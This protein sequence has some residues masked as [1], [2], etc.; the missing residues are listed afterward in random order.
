MFLGLIDC[1]GSAW[2]SGPS[3]GV[4][5]FQ[6]EPARAACSSATPLEWFPRSPGLFHTKRGEIARED[7]AHYRT[8]RSFEEHHASPHPIVYDLYGKIR[9]LEGGLGCIRLLPKQTECGTLWF[10]S[11]SSTQSAHEGVPIAMSDSD[12]NKC[13]GY[14]TQH[15]VMPCSITGRLRFLPKP[16]LSLYGD[17]VDVPGLYLLVEDLEPARSYAKLPE[18]RPIVSVA[19]TFGAAGYRASAAAHRSPRRQFASRPARSGPS[20]I[21]TWPSLADPDVPTSSSRMEQAKRRLSMPGTAP[22]H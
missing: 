2:L 18:G 11:A 6:A 22:E 15:G 13:I 19:V 3:S 20:R 1:S 9:M 16:L 5:V 8:S 7:P 21:P 12:Y 14:I 4:N 17:Y 10:M